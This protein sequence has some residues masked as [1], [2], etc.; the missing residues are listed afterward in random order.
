MMTQK[1]LAIRIFSND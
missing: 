1:R